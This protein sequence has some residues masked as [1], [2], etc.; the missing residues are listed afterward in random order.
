M[1]NKH[2]YLIK[3]LV[4]TN[5]SRKLSDTI[6]HWKKNI[7]EGLSENG[8]EKQKHSEPGRLYGTLPHALQYSKSLF[9]C[10]VMWFFF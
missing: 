9:Y 1:H 3:I 6:L 4:S 2:I 10:V 7:Y 5:I 8:E